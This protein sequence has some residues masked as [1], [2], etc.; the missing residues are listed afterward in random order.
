MCYE[1]DSV[2]RPVSR[3][4][5]SSCEPVRPFLWSPRHRGL[6]AA[7]PGGSGGIPCPAAPCGT[8]DRPPLFDLAP[9]GV[10]RAAAVAGSAV[11]S[12]P[13]VSPLPGAPSVSRWAGGPGGLFSVA[14][15]LGSRPPGVT[16]HRHP[17]EPGLSSSGASRPRQRPP[18]RLT[19]RGCALAA[20][21]SSPARPRRAP[22]AHSAPIPRPGHE[23][24]GHEKPGREKPGREKPGR[25]RPGR[26]TGA[27]PK[28]QT[29]RPRPGRA[30]RAMALGG[31]APR[32][33]RPDS[34]R[35]HELAPRYPAARPP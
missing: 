33:R 2:R 11:G 17:V 14:L 15:S 32:A 18:S 12:C 4:L 26:E 27:R 19:R 3:V 22:R 6:R 7:N 29:E 10:C 9:G 13:T 30:P 21:G 16:R 31:G 34:G 8:P 25:E 24:P 1:R 23:K 28:R 35:G 20:G 5:S